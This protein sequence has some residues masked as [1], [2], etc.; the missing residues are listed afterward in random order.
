MDELERDLTFCG[1]EG[2]E[3]YGKML[4]AQLRIGIVS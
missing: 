2:L 3:G 1:R 4:L